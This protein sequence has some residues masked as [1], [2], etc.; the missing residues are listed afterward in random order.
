MRADPPSPFPPGLNRVNID[1]IGSLH[2]HYTLNYN[3]LFKAKKT[4]SKSVL[5]S[6]KSRLGSIA[7]V[8]NISMVVN[9][10]FV[11]AVI[12]KPRGD[13]T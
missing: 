2:I 10:D 12:S 3:H 5:Y 13:S 11:I 9:K 1:N 4:K 6:T 7:K 8:N